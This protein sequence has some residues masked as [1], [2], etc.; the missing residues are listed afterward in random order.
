MKMWA[1]YTGVILI[2]GGPKSIRN[3]FKVA[4]EALDNGEV[5]GVFAEGGISRSN[6]VRSF[7]PGVMKILEDRK[8]PIIPVYFDELWGSIFSY[9]EGKALTKFPR[10]FRRPV[11]IHFGKPIDPQPQT[12]HEIQKSVQRLSTQT[13][14]NYAGKISP[15]IVEFIYSCKRQKRKSKITD[16]LRSEETGG[17]LLTRALVLRRLLRREVYSPEEIY[18]G[19]LIPPTVGGAI[20]NLS[21]GLDK[22]I[23]VNLNYSLSEELINHCIKEA[24]IKHVLTTRQVAEKLNFNLDAEMVFLDDLKD[25]VT[26]ADKGLSWF[27]AFVMPGFLLVQKLGLNKI[28]PDD[29]MTIVFTSG[30]TGVPKGVMLTHQNI[31]FDVRGFE[32]A[33]TFRPNEDTILGVLPFFHSFG[34]TVTL[35]APMMCDIRGAY[36]LN[37]LDAKQIGKLAKR[38][39]A[40]MLMATPTFLR[41]YMRRCSVE[42]FATL[43]AVVTGAERLPPELATQF[44]EKFG[45]V[46][47][48]GYGVT[49][50]SPGV[51]S[52]IPPSR[53]AGNFQVD[54]KPG[55]VGRPIANVSAKVVDLES[56]EELP[57]NESGMLWISGPI[58]MKG[59]L[60]NPVAT[61]E[62]IVDGWYKTGDV[63]MIDEDGFIKITG[64][65]SRFSKIGGEMVPHLKIEELLSEF[66]DL[67]PDDDDDDHLAVAVTA[68]P[69][70]RK[71]ERLVV[72][73]TRDHK[74]VDEMTTILKDA[75]LPNVF[76]PST[77]SF[78]RV[79]ALPILGTGKIDL[80]GIKD[81]ALEV[82]SA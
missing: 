55:T 61:D 49:E 70:E 28:K 15:P 81:K 62:V 46:P 36:H 25:K 72:L 79:D 31:Y 13:V 67:T 53:Q 30:S 50:L 43:D 23:A 71:G 26:G 60:N 10:T 58:V 12:M 4:R 18:V 24:G 68:V 78:F 37:P 74:T 64:R 17:M 8:V 69:C 65:I 57:P 35:W 29:V 52:N 76:I 59:Y 42:Q 63:A 73:Y 41:T 82:T 45:V 6:Q 56:G 51:A 3:A 2:S 22:K 77:D 66:L 9:S 54:S 21:L 80:K 5:L 11:S 32:K 1:D 75:G 39:K 16:S 20:V 40:T 47:V 48:E 19:V 44:E 27:E 33:A 34:Y 7:K 14:K 38:A